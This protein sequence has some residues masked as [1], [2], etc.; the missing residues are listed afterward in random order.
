MGV[1]ILIQPWN[2]LDDNCY[3][4]L[5]W[6][7]LV[8]SI[9]CEVEL[10]HLIYNTELKFVYISSFHDIIVIIKLLTYSVNLSICS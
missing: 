8:S 4:L 7:I 5:R 9:L 3:V 6:I 2:V 10:L 1:A